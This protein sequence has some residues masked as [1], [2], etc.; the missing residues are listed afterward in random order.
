MQAKNSLDDN[1][2]EIGGLYRVREQHIINVYDSADVNARFYEK[3]TI[4]GGAV[5]II[6]DKIP[7]D[8]HQGPSGTMLAFTRKGLG[9]LPMGSDEYNEWRYEKLA[10]SY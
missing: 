9:R 8:R 6:L 1:S 2:L 4:L 7:Y 3:Y 10:N 5:F